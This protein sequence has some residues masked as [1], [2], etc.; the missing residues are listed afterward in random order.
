MKQNNQDAKQNNMELKTMKKKLGFESTDQ[1]D[2]RIA[3][4]EFKLWTESITLKEE[5]K[6][7]EEIKQLKRD[8]PKVANYYQK[9]AEV[10]EGKANFDLEGKSMKEALDLISAEMAT[11]KLRKQELS[12]ELKKLVDERQ[13][14]MGDMPQL[15]EKRDELNQ[16]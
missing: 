13:A 7:L 12:E 1:I 3:S 16:K 5:K 14:Q 11:H 8:K 4:I 15:F 9:E 2:D 6:L 10:Q